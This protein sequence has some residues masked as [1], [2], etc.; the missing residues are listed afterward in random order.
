VTTCSFWLPVSRQN[1][2]ADGAVTVTLGHSATS[3]GVGNP[4]NRPIWPL[5]S[6]VGAVAATLAGLE[7]SAILGIP[8]AYHV[9]P[10]MTSY[11]INVYHLI[12]IITCITCSYIICIYV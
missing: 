10:K 12:I 4:R 6:V 5:S 7:K 8:Y 2:Q 1:G 9:S 11:D 3:W